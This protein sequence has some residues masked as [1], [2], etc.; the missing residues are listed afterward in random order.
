MLKLLRALDIDESEIPVLNIG[1][2]E[3]FTDYIDFIC[4]DEM[5]ADLMQG[6]DVNGRMFVSARMQYR[7]TRVRAIDEE[8]TV[9]KPAKTH[10]CVVTIFE[11]YRDPPNLL[12]IGTN[13][14]PNYFGFDS[15]VRSD[16][17]L[18]FLADRI[19]KMYR[20][21]SIEG[22]RYFGYLPFEVHTM[23]EVTLFM[24]EKREEIKSLLMQVLYRDVAG[25]VME[26][27]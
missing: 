12:A 3:G 11:R 18:M 16:E 15:R 20:G 6:Q 19:G 1:T 17:H 13:S 7:E 23:P 10:S 2:R 22:V 25:V 5:T 27:I 14:F 26:Y 24:P 4:P 21:E 9:E 8:E